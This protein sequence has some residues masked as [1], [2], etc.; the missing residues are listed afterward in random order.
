VYAESI[1]FWLVQSNGV[2]PLCGSAFIRRQTQSALNVLVV[3]MVNY[4]ADLGLINAKHLSEYV[5]RLAW[6]KRAY[7]THGVNGQLI[8]TLITSLF[9]AGSPAAI[10]FR[11]IAIHVNS[12]KRCTWRARSHV[13]EKRSEIIRPLF[14][15]ANPATTIACVGVMAPIKAAGFRLAPRLVFA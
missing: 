11:V 10:L 2:V 13:G 3:A 12:V 14:A 1:A 4:M 6:I 7:G 5:L 8:A 15:H 9:D